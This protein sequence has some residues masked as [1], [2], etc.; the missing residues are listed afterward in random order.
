MN[1]PK[2][3]ENRLREFRKEKGLRQLDVANKLGFK[4]TDRI[5]K[6]EKGRSLPGVINLLKMAV[7][8]DVAPH[9]I[10]LQVVKNIADQF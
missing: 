9:E 5:S 8:Y 10:Y 1:I 2:P 3:Y 7:L 4:S 6:W